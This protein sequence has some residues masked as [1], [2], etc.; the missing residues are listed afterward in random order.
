MTIR[1]RGFLTVITALAMMGLASCDHYNCNSGATFGSSSCT[2]SG[3]GLGGGGGALNAAAFD[4]FLAAGG[5]D[6]SLD[7][8]FVDTS[9]NFTVIPNFVSRT[10]T[11]SGGFGGMVVVQKQWLYLAYGTE[12]DAYAIDRTTGA[13]T[14]LTTS[15][16]VYTG[17]EAY[18]STTDPGGNFLFVTGANDHQV[19][20][21][22]IN[23][24][25]GALT[26]VGSYPTGIFAA[27]PATD[28]LGKYLYVSAGNLGG[29]VDVFSISPAGSSTPGSLTPLAGNPFS[30][31]VAVL[32]GEPTGQFMLGVSG[33]GAN[34]GVGSDNHIYVYSINQSTG[35][36]T[37]VGSP[38][39]TTYIPATLAVHPT[40]KLV[41][42]FNQTGSGTSPMEGFTFNAGVLT[43][44]ASSPFTAI[45]AP[46]G[47]F[48]QSGAY[49]FMH[50]GTSLTVAG[51]DTTTGALTSIGTPIT[52]AGN[53]VAQSWA[54]TDAN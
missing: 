47:E 34:N 10:V 26:T 32:Q 17:T 30:V 33:N 20:V 54:V 8:A 42:T 40:G 3:S 50:P 39:A 11:G 51:V 19:W 31:A 48:D 24:T 13:L 6:G 9:S 38:F 27:Y 15:P 7:A 49:L 45:T 36:L 52:S 37:L 12:V 29:A 43:P 46:A 44:L 53:P 41:Y 22:A 4:F 21:F 28:G 1:V 2:P 35:A 18:S 25:T 16:F 5:L 23:Q 14:P